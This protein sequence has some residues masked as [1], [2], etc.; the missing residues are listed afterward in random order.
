VNRAIGT[1]V[2]RGARSRGKNAIGAENTARSRRPR[3]EA[4]PENP[5]PRRLLHGG[6]VQ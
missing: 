3:R 2:S 4:P 5:A 6:G 1:E